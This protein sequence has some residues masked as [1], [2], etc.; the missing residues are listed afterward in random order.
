MSRAAPLLNH[1][2]H[3]VDPRVTRTREHSLESILFI[4]ICGVIAGEDS[5][6][7]IEEF[8][9]DKIDFFSQF[10]DL[11]SG[12]PSHD[13][14]GRVFAALDTDAFAQG[15]VSWVQC[16]SETLA[17]PANDVVAIDGKTMRRSFD[18]A[19]GKAAIHLVSAFA[20]NNRLVLG[21]VRVDDKSNE[22][23]AIPELLRR[24]TLTGCLVTLDAMGCQKQIARDITT[25]GADYLLAL[26]GNHGELHR[27]VI[28][29]FAH[30]DQTAADTSAVCHRHE[31]VTAGHGRVEKRVVEAVPCDWHP[32]RSKWSGLQAFVRVT[33]ERH[34]GDTASREVRYFLSSL[35]AALIAR[36]ADGIR[37]HWRIE[38]DLHWTLDM[39]FDED[40]QRMRSGDAPANMALLN[41]I[42]LNL[43]KQD[44][45][46][47]LGIKNKRRKAARREDYLLRVLAAAGM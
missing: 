45:S 5:W 26:K 24:L 9:C 22:I 44:K 3:L 21:Q 37:Q 29:Y 47:K 7:G 8:A 43:L 13:T 15:F 38:N 12:I 36:Q 25:A 42:A 6:A 28:D 33:A 14:F 10:V 27:D 19:N 35:P 18:K 20:S 32:D 17:L 4:A 40:Q 16:V 23:T 11:P 39:A 2:S 34:I 46:C 30:L 1:F 31:D 41:K